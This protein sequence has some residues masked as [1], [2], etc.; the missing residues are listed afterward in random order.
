[1]IPNEVLTYVSISLFLAIL[2][3]KV[4]VNFLVNSLASHRDLMVKHLKRLVKLNPKKVQVKLYTVSSCNIPLFRFRQLYLIL[5]LLYQS[6][7][8]INHFHGTHTK[9]MVTEKSALIGNFININFND[10]KSI[11]CYLFNQQEHQIGKR[12][13]TA[14]LQEL[15]SFSPQ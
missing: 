8:K 7:Q 10:L 11:K 9:M 14:Q 1:M 2:E 5:L 15:H 6:I 13:I 3:R 4:T 12:I